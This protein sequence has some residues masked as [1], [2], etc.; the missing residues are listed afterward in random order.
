MT[1]TPQQE[2]D[3]APVVYEWNML[4]AAAERLRSAIHSGDS[5]LTNL[6][7][8]AFVVHFRQLGHFFF[9]GPQ[10]GDL[11]VGPFVGNQSWKAATGRKNRWHDLLLRASKQVA[12]L[13]AERQFTS[14]DKPKQHWPVSRLVGEV[15]E[16]LQVFC[17][18]T[19]F[20]G[21]PGIVPSTGVLVLVMGN[22]GSM[23]AEHFITTATNA[24]TVCNSVAAHRAVNATDS[25]S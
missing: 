11:H 3:L 19:G 21:F 22:G 18:R 23:S 17:D 14:H 5:L 25:C 10:K 16:E 24:P 15:A 6:M 20:A 8:E 4:V 2:Q 13:T 1:L 12:H 9:T 7:L